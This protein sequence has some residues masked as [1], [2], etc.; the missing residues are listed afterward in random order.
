M[1]SSGAS[2]AGKYSGNGISQPPVAL[3]LFAPQNVTPPMVGK[4]M[5]A[6]KRCQLRSADGATA[7]SSARAAAATAAGSGA[8]RRREL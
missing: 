6:V 3:G 5:K 2:P 8:G 4:G 1:P 7:S